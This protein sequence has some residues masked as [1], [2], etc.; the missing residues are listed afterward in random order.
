MPIEKRMRGLE[1]VTPNYEDGGRVA[2]CGDVS[3]PQGDA[4]K[5]VAEEQRSVEAYAQA[6]VQVAETKI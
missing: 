4:A 6:T 1:D 3:D 5:A 2:T